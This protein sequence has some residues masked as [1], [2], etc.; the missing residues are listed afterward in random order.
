MLQ[1]LPN[2]AFLKQKRRNIRL[3]YKKACCEMQAKAL[4]KCEF[5]KNSRMRA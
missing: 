2:F 4:G 1:N 5:P 3:Y